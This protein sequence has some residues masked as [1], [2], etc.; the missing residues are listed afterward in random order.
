M[1]Y[2]RL[3]AEA[4][5]KFDDVSLLA[6][7]KDPAN[8]KFIPTGCL[9]LDICLGK[10][11]FP[12]GRIF[13]LAGFESTGK[14]S[15]GACCF[16]SAQRAGALTV[17]FDTESNYD[18][19]WATRLGIDPEKTI[20]VQPDSLQDAFSRLEWLIQKL[21]R[22]KEIPMFVLFDSVA[23]LPT[24]EEAMK[25]FG[26]YQIGHHARI[27]AHALRRITRMI[28]D[29]QVAILFINQLKEKIGIG[30]GPKTMKIGGH[31]VG[32]H[33]AAM[34][35]VERKSIA[36]NSDD[37]PYA[38]NCRIVATKN[39]ISTPFKS[40]N[41]R[42]TFRYGVDNALTVLEQLVKL[43]VIEYKMGWYKY[44]GHS[45]HE[46]DILEKIETDRLEELVRERLGLKYEQIFS[47][48][49]S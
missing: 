23:A 22:H 26:E 47:D 17:L 33:S 24:A 41:F 46:D 37:E 18:V 42:C 10:P 43:E 14:S 21:E 4:T 1:D 11:G 2:Q 49:G 19:S 9:A 40:A 34:F 5:K 48:E 39:K 31:A 29:L 6:S 16:A 13:E 44:S 27:M 8:N 3:I 38:I 12:V 30:P 15:I 36:K 20:L 32:Y 28:W 45:Y 35:D 7:F 25:G